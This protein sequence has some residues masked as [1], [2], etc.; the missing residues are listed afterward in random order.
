MGETEVEKQIGS[1]RIDYLDALRTVACFTV[2]MLHVAALN[3]YNLDF[4]CREWNIFMCYESIVN[5][6]VPMFVMISGAVML[7]KE[8]SYKRVWGKCGRI[9]VLFIAWSA[10]YLAFDF[11]V[12]GIETYKNAI[13]LQVLLQGHYHMWFLIML[14][15]LYLIVPLVKAATTK[16]EHLKAFLILALIFTFIIPQLTIILF[17]STCK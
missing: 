11:A 9:A 15:G 13:W 14:F 12:Y 6:A 5:W 17:E 16:R 2:V 8:Y 1:D 4:R 7:E 3:T 10:V